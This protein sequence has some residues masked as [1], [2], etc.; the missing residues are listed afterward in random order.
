MISMISITHIHHNNLELSLYVIYLTQGRRKEGRGES[1]E[2][3]AEER[4][5]RLHS[6]RKECKA[7]FFSCQR[8]RSQSNI[9]PVC[10]S[11]CLC[12]WFCLLVSAVEQNREG[13]IPYRYTTEKNTTQVQDRSV[14][15]GRRMKDD[16]DFGLTAHSLIF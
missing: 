12:L 5:T 11:L 6:C 2:G 13:Y 1:E 3:K 4:Q 8:R 16:I 10:S 15:K 9:S 7:S 14:K